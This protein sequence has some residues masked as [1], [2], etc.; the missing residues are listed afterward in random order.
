VEDDPPFRVFWGDTHGH[1]QYAEGQGSP[2]H[3][4]AFARDDARLDF[5]VLSEHD[6]WMDDFEWRTMRELSASYR[7]EGRFLPFLGYEWTAPPA[8]G[9][10]HN[11]FFR[12]DVDWRVG[13]QI[14][15]ELGRLYRALRRAYAED[16]V[17]V[18][19][20]A[21]APGDWRQSDGSIER[22]VEIASTHGT[23]EF[24]GNRYLEQGW[25]VGFIG[26]TDNHHGH[27]GY[28]DTGTT[29]H[30][31]RNGLA[32]VLAPELTGDALF[33]AMR[34]I[35]AYAT[36]GERILLDVSLGGAP[37]GTRVPATTERR[38]TVRAS[39]TAPID[40]IDVVKNGDVVL[41]KSYLGA[42]LAPTSWVRVAFASS[43][44]VEEHRAPREYRVWSGS[45]EVAGA[46]L[47]ELEAPDLE[48]RHVER[49][50]RSAEDPSRVEVELLTRGR[51]NV[52]LLG[53]DGVTPESTLRIRI[54][55]GRIG[56]ARADAPVLDAED[57]AFRLG[58]V[59]EEPRVVPLGPAD[60]RAADTVTVDLVDLGAALDRTL[61][62]TDLGA[63]KEG[64]YYYVRVTQLGGERAWSSPFW[65]GG[66]ARTPATSLERTPEEDRGVSGDRRTP[67]RAAARGPRR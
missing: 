50:E 56:P 47:R 6:V 39:G 1:T 21:H 19:P 38:F 20:H 41:H 44:E 29:F 54:D 37:M 53:L 33:G 5:V 63:A 7:E 18:I 27:P 26:S 9:G 4:F 23:F 34:E 11:V 55:Q 17:M 43:S 65:V 40:S 8:R 58:D 45:L 49:V 35:K 15:P 57:L 46:R 28:P 32:A 12:R 10:H 51:A 31:E 30:T 24:F 67:R 16:D 25:Q 66:A 42:P 36:S 62:W 52:V 22:L 13:A 61:E 2:S 3:Y 59:A 48:N 60:D 64:D 14:A